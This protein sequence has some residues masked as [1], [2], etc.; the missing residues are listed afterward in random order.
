M[1][2]FQFLLNVDA[3]PSGELPQDVHFGS[4]ADGRQGDYCAI[5]G[6][7]A[8]WSFTLE[9]GILSSTLSYSVAP[10][11]FVINHRGTIYWLDYANRNAQ[12]FR[13]RF[14]A[15]T[16]TQLPTGEVLAYDFC[17]ACL[18]EGNGLRWQATDLSRDDLV[19]ERIEG[20][21]AIFSGWR[22]SPDQVFRFSIDL[23]TGR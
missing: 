12:V 14:G 10:G 11:V 22:T 16:S 8:R 17:D 19:F 3:P 18:V 23:A 15:Y 20:N 1:E 6:P 7:D 2:E 21:A 13:G 5:L 9:P 4:K